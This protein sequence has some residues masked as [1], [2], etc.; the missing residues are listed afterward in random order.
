MRLLKYLSLAALLLSS[1]K[2]QMEPITWKD[3]KLKKRAE[4]VKTRKYEN[5]FNWQNEDCMTKKWMPQGITSTAH[6]SSP[7]KKYLVV[8]WYDRKTNKGARVSFIDISDMSN[9]SYNHVLLVQ[10]D[11]DKAFAALKTDEGKNLHAGGIAWLGDKIYVAETGKGFRVFNPDVIFKANP[12]DSEI[13]VYENKISGA[14]Y[15]YIMPQIDKIECS[16]GKNLPHGFSNVSVSLCNDGTKKLITGSYTTKK[17]NFSK[18]TND[19]IVWDLEKIVKSFTHPYERVQGVVMIN[20]YI[21]LSRGGKKG[22]LTRWDYK[23]NKFKQHS[24][25]KGCQD[26]T[27]MPQTDEIWSLTEYAG[28]RIVFSVEAK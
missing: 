28:K 10:P 26:L 19:V 9:I 21:F 23:K 17:G 13:G 27:Y 6:S 18:R 15:A 16:N 7:D 14:N 24:F 20:D 12:M 1:S 2:A 11:E 22:R 4:V 5:C 25:P 8:S 3:V